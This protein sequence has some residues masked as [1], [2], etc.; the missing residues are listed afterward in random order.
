M[1]LFRQANS[2][3]FPREPVQCSEIQTRGFAWAHSSLFLF[4]DMPEIDIF[5]T[6]VFTG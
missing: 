2:S 3:I 6:E 5:D 4:L 1:M